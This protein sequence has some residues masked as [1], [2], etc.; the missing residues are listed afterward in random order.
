MLTVVLAM[1]V[2]GEAPALDLELSCPGQYSVLETSEARVGRAGEEKTR[3]TVETRVMRP[4]T[5]T[6]TLSGD[7]GEIVYPDGVRRRLSSITA[8][9]RR[10]R[11]EYVQKLLVLKF[12][13]TMEINRLTGEVRV[14]D[15][16]DVAFQG[17]CS[18]VSTKPKF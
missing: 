15:G 18:A 13:F 8:D 7:A 10:I 3:A 2:A 16:R 1:A 14:A 17:T 5:A 6:I 12:T 9:E 4:G 11:G